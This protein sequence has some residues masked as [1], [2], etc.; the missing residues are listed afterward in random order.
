MKN[1]CEILEK[2]SFFVKQNKIILGGLEISTLENFNE[3]ILEVENKI[4]GLPELKIIEDMLSYSKGIILRD[5]I[6]LHPDIVPF[7]DISM[8][9]ELKKI[10]W[11]SYIH[12]N[13]SLFYDLLEKYKMLSSAIDNIS[14]DK[15]RWKNTL[16]V[17]NERFYFP[18]RMNVSNLKSS[19]IGESLPHVGF[20]FSNQDNTAMAHFSRKELDKLDT[21]SQGEKRALYLLNIIFDLE[22][23]KN[24]EEEILIVID[25]IADSFDYKNEYAIIEYICE[26]ADYDNVKILFLTHN[27]DFYRAVSS[28]LFI[29]RNHR[30]L[31]FSVNGN[32]IFEE[33]KYQNQPFRAWKEHPDKKSILAMIPFISNIV[34]YGRDR[35]VSVKGDDYDF[36]TSLLHEKFD[37]YSITFMDLLAIFREYLDID[38]LG[39]YFNL[40]DGVIYEL[41]REC[42]GIKNSDDSLENRVI[43][44]MGIC[45]LAEK[46]MKEAISAYTGILKWKG[47]GRDKCNG[48]SVSFLKYVDSKR[49]QTGLLIK[50]YKQ[51]GD[52][53][54]KTVMSEVSI[55]TPENI[56]FNSFMYEPILDMDIIELLN[57]YK[58]IKSLT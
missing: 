44:S 10:L 18:F 22:R 39:E 56:H 2:N 45:H 11:I 41:Y 54:S 58:K 13:T 37:T 14:L 52:I 25:D 16:G 32:I 51:F 33:E 7:L 12:E 4:K 3:R 21:L 15:T 6:E 29:T 28:R 8:L 38:N 17:F 30:L 35:G 53:F 40:N 9:P 31:A 36:L 5:I 20:S 57:L 26:L 1:I 47:S 27:Y 50:G 55:M 19:I 43:L 42:D 34:E 48:D 46:F 49:N 23:I 24:L